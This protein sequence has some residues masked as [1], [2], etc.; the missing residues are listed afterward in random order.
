[1]TSDDNGDVMFVF[2]DKYLWED[3]GFTVKFD[4]VMSE[5]SIA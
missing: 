3:K 5:I 4:K 1:M 2:S